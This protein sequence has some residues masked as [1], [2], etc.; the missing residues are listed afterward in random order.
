MTCCVPKWINHSPSRPQMKHFSLGEH[1]KIGKRGQA[2]TADLWAQTAIKTTQKLIAIIRCYCHTEIQWH[3]PVMTQGA[4]TY[5]WVMRT[6]YE[7]RL[8][9]VVRRD[10]DLSL[11]EPLN[12]PYRNIEPGNKYLS[13]DERLPQH[14]KTRQ[15]QIRSVTRLSN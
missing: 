9:L 2:D 13:A 12:V 15:Q 8:T 14:N 7:N 1:I 3:N 10:K 5:S 4:H 6:I 11:E